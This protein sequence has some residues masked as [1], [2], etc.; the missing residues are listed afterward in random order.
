MH[1]RT[2]RTLIACLIC[3]LFAGIVWAF[4]EPR[5]ISV[6]HTEIENPDIPPA[7]NGV[8]I[9]Y[10]A[11]IH[12]G[13]L[14]GRSHVIRTIDTI[15]AEQPD[16]VL[17]GGDYTDGDFAEIVDT[18][19]DLLY[20]EIEELCSVPL[21]VVGVPGNHDRG[22]STYRGLMRI[23]RV[24]RAGITVLENEHTQIWKD[25]AFIEIVGTEDLGTGH[26]DLAAA[27]AG[28]GPDNFSILLAHNPDVLPT[29]LLE[30]EAA[31][32]DLVLAGHTHGGQVTFFGLWA[33]IMPSKHGQRFRS[34]WLEVEGVPVLVTRGI[35]VVILP[36]RFF[37]PPQ[38]HVITL[39]CSAG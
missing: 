8:R 5:L 30:A 25:D 24:R 28:V 31:D 37:A 38:I 29:G 33:P 17:L 7:F 2:K 32:F 26:P 23:E 16:L 1:P 13:G 21:G 4:I 19:G 3:L 9:V 39:K 35:G 20:P 36:V 22:M 11:D 14:L 27:A 34:G 10:A 12:A 6:E 15:L 18:G